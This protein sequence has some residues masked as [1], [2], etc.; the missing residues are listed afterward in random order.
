[1]LAHLTT[2][3]PPL[4]HIGIQPPPPQRCS[5]GLSSSDIALIVLI[6]VL[7]IALVIVIILLVA[8][9]RGKSFFTPSSLLSIADTDKDFAISMDAF[10]D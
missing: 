5:D 3:S 6:P 9:A 1:M 8:V 2:P 4:H 10:K 7:V